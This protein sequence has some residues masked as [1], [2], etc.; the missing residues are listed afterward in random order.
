MLTKNYKNYRKSLFWGTFDSYRQMVAV[1]GTKFTPAINARTGPTGDLG[2]TLRTGSLH[3][4]N[5][6][7]QSNYGAVFFGS[8]STPPTEDDYAGETGISAT[9]FSI[10]EDRYAQAVDFSYAERAWTLKNGSENEAVI[11][12]ICLFGSVGTSASNNVAYVCL[13]ERTVL[14]DPII[15][16]PGEA[17]TITV[18]V[19]NMIDW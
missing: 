11:R 15:I 5:P 2:N 19:E 8:G 18:R 17:K 3:F 10:I 7:L 14:D 6:S 1:D 4:G 13:M 9:G 12:E 16:K